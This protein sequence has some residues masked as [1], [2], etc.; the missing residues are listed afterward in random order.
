MRF[1]AFLIHTRKILEMSMFFQGVDILL[2]DR[3]MKHDV[4]DAWPRRR[5]KFA[6][7]L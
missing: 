1:L 6:R 5:E 2:I 3:A 7:V 4:V